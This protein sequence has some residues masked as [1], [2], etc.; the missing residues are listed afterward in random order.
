[1]SAFS[2]WMTAANPFHREAASDNRAART[3]CVNRILRTSRRET[4]ARSRAEQKNLRGRNRPAINADCENQNRSGGRQTAG[5]QNRRIRLSTESRHDRLGQ[6]SHFNSSKA[7]R[8]S[9][10]PENPFP[11]PRI[12]SRRWNC[13]RPRPIQPAA[14]IHADAAGN[15]RAANAAHGCVAAHFRFFCS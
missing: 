11:R 3:D 13:A 8:G 1:M 10:P 2:K 6:T 12:F 5:F 15:F 14:R 4:A 7:S 9:T